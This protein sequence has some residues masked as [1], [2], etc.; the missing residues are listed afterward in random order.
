MR[1]FTLIIINRLMVTLTKRRIKR[2]YDPLHHLMLE[3]LR[4]QVHN[5]RNKK[6]NSL[7]LYLL[8]S[9]FFFL[10][11]SDRSNSSVTCV[12]RHNFFFRFISLKFKLW[13]T[14][15]RREGQRIRKLVEEETYL[16]RHWMYSGH[17][18]HDISFLF[19]YFSRN[20]NIMMLF[21]W[22]GK[23]YACFVIKEVNERNSFQSAL[24]M[25]C[26]TITNSI[27]CTHEMCVC[28]CVYNSF[29]NWKNRIIQGQD[30]KS[31]FS[32]HTLI[33]NYID[34]HETNE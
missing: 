26:T 4:C 17:T 31:F 28:V 6:I 18:N 34:R 24:N 19:H 5:E 20:S 1:V 11:I 27:I 10:F 22:N 23:G 13:I 29:N 25:A 30:Q 14:M 9:S 21:R 16:M 32:R 8:W 12:Y 3:L 7:S 2:K 15:L 33:R